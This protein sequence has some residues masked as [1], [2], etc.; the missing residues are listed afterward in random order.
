[1]V[2]TDMVDTYVVDVDTDTDYDNFSGVTIFSLTTIFLTSP[3]TPPVN[4]S[5]IQ[6]VLHST[7]STV[8]WSVIWSDMPSE[9]GLVETKRGF[10]D[11]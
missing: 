9:L 3:L 1:M 4:W 8:N 6:L 5:L 11:F 10:V 2:D 7:G